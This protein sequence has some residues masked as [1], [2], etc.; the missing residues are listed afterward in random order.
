MQ[1]GRILQSTG[2][3]YWLQT[4]DGQEAEARLRGKLKLSDTKATNPVAVGDWVMC[5]T[6]DASEAWIITEVLP[7]SNAIVRQSPRK[8]HHTHTIA[9]NIDQ[10]LLLVTLSQP[11]TSLGFV[12]RFLAVAEYDDIPTVL[13]FNK[14]DIYTD[15]ELANYHE[16]SQLY[17]SLGYTCVLVSAE[18]GYG[19]AELNTLLAHKTN[20]LVGHSGVG[21]STLLNYLHPSLQL[22]TQQIS[23]YSGKGQHTTTAATMFYLP[24]GS[25]AIIDTPGI[26]LLALVALE[27]QQVG[28]YFREIKQYAQQCKYSNCLHID[29]PKCAVK[30]ALDQQRITP[31][32]YASYLKIVTDIESINYWERL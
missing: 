21:K 9:A 20:L 22:R 7:R 2:S 30:Q 17:S 18:T 6:E 1:K 26:K 3:W 5:H 4:A 27:P 19:I 28:F 8:A 15:D 14:Q 25:T 11:R 13:V 32:R 10:L 23:D 31:R 16:A 12:D 29:E 24:D